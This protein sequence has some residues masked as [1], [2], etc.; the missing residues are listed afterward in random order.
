M[1]A[2]SDTVYIEPKVIKK[3]DVRKSPRYFKVPLVMMVKKI[4]PSRIPGSNLT[5]GNSRIPI[6]TYGSVS[7]R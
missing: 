4:S 7:S 6:L 5:R 1:V 2:S 3:M